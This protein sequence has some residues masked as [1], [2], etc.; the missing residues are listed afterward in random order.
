MALTSYL[1]W[2]FLSGCSGDSV[3]T[4]AFFRD[5]ECGGYADPSLDVIGFIERESGEV[6]RDFYARSICFKRVNLWEREHTIKYIIRY[7]GDDDRRVE[8]SAEISAEKGDH[9]GRIP[10]FDNNYIYCSMYAAG[11]RFTDSLDA[12]VEVVD[13]FEYSCDP[14]KGILVEEAKRDFLRAMQEVWVFPY[15]D[16]HTL[17]ILPEDQLSD[18][19]F[20]GVYHL[21]FEQV[22]SCYLTE[23]FDLEVHNECSTGAWLSVE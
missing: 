18:G 11:L 4:D 12:G 15:L 1:L 3:E 23:P 5:Q 17:D 8:V 21:F 14:P 19:H 22:E 10:I 7:H 16:I 20:S 13:R 6:F 2:A 9:K